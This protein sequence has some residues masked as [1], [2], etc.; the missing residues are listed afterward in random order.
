MDGN[1]YWYKDGTIL[2]YWDHLKILHRLDGPAITYYDGQQLYFI[3]GENYNINDFNKY[4][5]LSK[6]IYG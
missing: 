2:S 1:K 3:D 5:D 4:K 6:L